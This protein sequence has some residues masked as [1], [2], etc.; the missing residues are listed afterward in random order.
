MGLEIKKGLIYLFYSSALSVFIAVCNG[1]LK[2]SSSGTSCVQSP[3]PSSVRPNY[4]TLS[5]QHSALTG[6]RLPFEKSGQD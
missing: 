4:G 3:M 1:I 6:R 5:S 2:H